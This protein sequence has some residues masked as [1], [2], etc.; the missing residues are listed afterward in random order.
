MRRAKLD[1]L[2]G[3]VSG[4]RLP[5]ARCPGTRKSRLE[6]PRGFLN[7]SRTGQAKVLVVGKNPGHPIDEEHEFYRS[8]R[9]EPMSKLSA[10]FYEEAL[11]R[12]NF[13]ANTRGLTFHTRLMNYLRSILN[14]TDTE[15]VRKV[16][17]TNLVKC[18]TKDKTKQLHP[19][20]KHTCYER[21]LSSEIQLIEPKVIIAL[22]KEAF[23]FLDK[24]KD[25]HSVEQL[26]YLY[27]PSYHWPQPGRKEGLKKARRIFKR[28][29]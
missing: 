12:K 29:V 5:C 27:H 25:E 24:N 3:A 7:G 22:G 18:S 4:C 10:R 20:T 19:I 6:R 13:L 16:A 17:F 21:F 8:S 15:I 26:A 9:N 2:Y 23:E 11:L 1:K 14:L 28:M